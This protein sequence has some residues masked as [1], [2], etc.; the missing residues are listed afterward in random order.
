MLADLSTIKDRYDVVLM[1]PPWEYSGSTSKWGACAKHYATMTMGE[2]KTMDLQSILNK[3][4]VVFMWATGPKLHN[5]LDLGCAL[6]LHYRG[7]AFVWVK[8]KK[9]GTP[10]GAQGVRPSIVKQLTEVCLAFST[11]E[12]GRPMALGSEAV[13]QT[14]F[15]PKTEHSA[16]PP[17][18]RARIELL[19]PNAKRI[20]LFSR[21]RV[22]T[23][24]SW[25]LEAPTLP[26]DKEEDED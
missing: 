6:G 21:E 4:A 15:A 5:A 17:E 8:T 11:V 19:Y 18:V 12:K 9:D 10:V 25:G 13:C 24:A 20:E 22:P 14:V 2:L 23:W 3:P 7:I 1:D 16:K 26:K